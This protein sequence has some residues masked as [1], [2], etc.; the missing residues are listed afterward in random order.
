MLTP[1]PPLVAW[2]RRYERPPYSSAGG[3]GGG[4]GSDGA[5]GVRFG[6]RLEAVKASSWGL[7]GTQPSVRC[8]SKP[9]V[10]RTLPL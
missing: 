2:Q 4:G 8:Q 9:R 5:G 1:P 6:M 10:A 3:G 7:G